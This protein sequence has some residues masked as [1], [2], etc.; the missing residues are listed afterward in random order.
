LEVNGLKQLVM[1]ASLLVREL[2]ASRPRRVEEAFGT[3]EE[4][5]LPG[6]LRLLAVEHLHGQIRHGVIRMSAS[7]RGVS[8]SLGLG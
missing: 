7:C 5:H 2:F 3:I 6:Q 4:E 8:L 1:L